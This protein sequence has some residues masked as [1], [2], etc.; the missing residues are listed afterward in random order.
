MLGR[1]NPKI[2]TNKMEFIDLIL[3]MREKEK[4]R[5][6]ESKREIYYCVGKIA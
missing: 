4:D 3:G 1:P 5:E 6:A 2:S